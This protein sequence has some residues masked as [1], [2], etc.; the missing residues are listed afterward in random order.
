MD[1]FLDILRRRGN[2]YLDR[3]EKG[4][5][6]VLVFDYEIILDGRTLDRP[7][8]YTLAQINDRREHAGDV[9]FFP[10]EDDGAPCR[11]ESGAM[12]PKNGR[13]LSSTP[14]QDRHRLSAVPKGIHKSARS[15]MMA[16]RSMWFFFDNYV[17][18]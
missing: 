11:R 12:T 2:N 16:I 10:P 9:Q 18:L 5:P 13:S 7:V 4:Q 15:W 8:N 17:K 3:L 1:I 6:P 14:G